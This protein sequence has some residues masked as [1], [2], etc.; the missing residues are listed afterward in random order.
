[1]GE[2]ARV[3]SPVEK[4]VRRHAGQGRM[5]ATKAYKAGMFQSSGSYH[6]WI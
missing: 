6:Y 1:M 3:S 4:Q 2:H 5:A